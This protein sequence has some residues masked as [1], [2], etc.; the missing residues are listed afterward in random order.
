[1]RRQEPATPNQ[2]SCLQRGRACKRG[3]SNATTTDKEN[4]S[5]SDNNNNNNSSTNTAHD[6]SRMGT[7]TTTKQLLQTRTPQLTKRLSCQREVEC[8]GPRRVG[9]R[10]EKHARSSIGTRHCRL[11]QGLQ[12]CQAR[13]YVTIESPRTYK[14]MTPPC[15]KSLKR[16]PKQH[17][18]R[19][20]TTLSTLGEA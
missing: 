8:I 16:T 20:R 4:T 11:A 9:A 7:T 10:V 3:E 2:G 6:E 18:H 1:M 5:H 14:P 15:S 19:T 13:L 12:G 17:T